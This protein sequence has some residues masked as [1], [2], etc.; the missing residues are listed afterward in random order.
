M[1]PSAVAET[2]VPR[3]P[4]VR[5]GIWGPS[6]AAT[7]QLLEASTAELPHVHR[8]HDLTVVLLRGHG[9]LWVEYR[10]HR[11]RAGDV[12]HIARGRPHHFHPA[13]G[14]VRALAIFTPT[15]DEVD[16]VPIAK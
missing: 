1:G 9:V 14:A 15:L 12:V 16:F 13:D 11:L 3:S 7:F 4:G 10:A 2:L 5:A 6:P 8:E